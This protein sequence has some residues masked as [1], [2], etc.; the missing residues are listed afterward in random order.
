MTGCPAFRFPWRWPAIGPPV[1]GVAEPGD[2]KVNEL[3]AFLDD[4]DRAIEDFVSGL[5]CTQGGAGVPWASAIVVAHDAINRAQYNVAAPYVFLCSG[6][7]DDVVVQQAVNYASNSGA[8]P[9]GLVLL[10]DGTFNFAPDAN[11]NDPTGGS[12]RLSGFSNGGDFGTIIN[13]A[14][15]T[16]DAAPLTGGAFDDFGDI[17]NLSLT[18]NA[19]QTH[20]I[21][22]ITRGVHIDNVDISGFNKTI[23][24]NSVAFNPI[25][26]SGDGMMTRC[27]VFQWISGIQCRVRIGGALVQIYGN[28]FF[29]GGGIGIQIDGQAIVTGNV[30]DGGTIAVKLS[31]TQT[32]S[33]I[34]DNSIRGDSS[35]T[36]VVQVEGARAKVSGNRLKFP[37]VL[38]TNGINVLAG[39]TDNMVTDN[40]LH[41][42]ATNPLVDAGTGTYAPAGSNF[43]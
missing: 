26:N 27:G 13:I 17:E 2:A 33:I 4:R 22:G 7:A 30:V 15:A 35:A 18:V 19:N 21:M 39:A 10:T 14:A 20:D 42:C 31:S 38:P 36:N 34:S 8:K 41:G 12:T 32:D 43:V 6:S 1:L 9:G 28:Q 5:P 16:H 24:A 37:T 25:G 11:V 29:G 3:L 23:T 40:Y